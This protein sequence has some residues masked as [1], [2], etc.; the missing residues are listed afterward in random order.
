MKS[1]IK[2]K[3]S[4]LNNQEDIIGKL[5]LSV[6]KFK[7]YLP[8]SKSSLSY[9]SISYILNDVI[10][11]DRK[12]IIEFG[13][14]ISTVYLAKLAKTSKKNLKITTIDHDEKWISILTNILKEEELIEYVN[15]IYC[16]LDSSSLSIENN[17]WY[18]ESVIKNNIKGM[19]FDLVIV[20]GPLAYEKEFEMS[21]YPALP[22]INNYLNKRNSIFLDDTNRNGEKKIVKLWEKQFDRC[23]LSLNTISM[24]SFKGSFF[25]IK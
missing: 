22:F 17:K 25:N 19:K 20:D 12:D 21:R 16:P 8:Y 18:S 23:F 7:T 4:F 3:L 2:H 13:G 14:G 11:N 6:F 15:L 5:N 9:S 1:K 24:I 10:I